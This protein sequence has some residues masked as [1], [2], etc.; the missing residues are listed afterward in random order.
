M[1]LQVE[2]RLVTNGHQSRSKVDADSSLQQP[3][4]GKTHNTPPSNGVNIV[5]VA[6]L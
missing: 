5:L 6:W 4:S 2:G 3:S 1:L